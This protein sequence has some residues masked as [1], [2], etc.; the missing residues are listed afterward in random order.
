MGGFQALMW[1]L[2]EARSWR[3]RWAG[4]LA[5]EGVTVIL[6]EG[7]HNRDPMAFWLDIESPKRLGRLTVWSSG[8]AVLEVGETE[9]GAI[10][11]SE[12]REITSRIGLQDALC[13][14][15]AWVEEP[16][17]GGPGR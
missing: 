4:P 1:A 5:Y 11:V 2:E 10:L 9:S 15:L 6:V 14:L 3:D 16:D 8:D 7:P 13:S 12:Q 17:Q